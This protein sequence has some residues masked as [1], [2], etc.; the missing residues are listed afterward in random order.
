MPEIIV[1]GGI[2]M[3]L[4]AYIPRSTQEGET[5]QATSVEFFLGGKGA[6]QAAASA[7]L[8]AKVSFVGTIGQDQFGID[9]KKLISKENI[10][11]SKLSSSRDQTGVAL[12]NVLKNGRNEVIAFPGANKQTSS[13]L[14]SDKKLKSCSIVIG[15]MELE[16]SQTYNLFLRAK[17]NGC[18]TILNLAPFK[19]I[20]KQLLKQTDI[21]IVNEIEFSGLTRRSSKK[22][23]LKFVENNFSRLDL[24]PQIK[25][26]V[27]MG[28]KGVVVFAG[29]IKKYFPSRKVKAIDTVGAGDCFVGAL[30]YFLLNDSDIFSA[31]HFAIC[32]SSISVT[33]KGAAESMPSIDEVVKIL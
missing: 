27:T 1:F 6:N 17:K 32:A 26:I 22:I 20:K 2:N 14:I 10:D 9:V 5:I 3:D 29:G 19:T 23:D 13:K 15:Q 24:P 4:F 21:L 28:E 33:R 8:G 11:I 12:I 7:R 31:T 16:E 25:L 18:Q 30:G